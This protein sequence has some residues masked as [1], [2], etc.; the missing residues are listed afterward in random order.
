MPSPSITIRLPHS[1]AFAAQSHGWCRLAPFSLDG[2]RL[3][4][5]V[6]LPKGGARRVNI[7]WSS[8]SDVVRVAVPGRKIGEA[9]REFL[10][11]R[12]RW[13]LRADEDFGEFW[14]LCRGH[15][16]LGHCR[17]KRTGALLRSCCTA[18]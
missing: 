4:W 1:P 13:M 3:D 6:R 5:A 17:S 14:E 11:S 9:D 2:D 7:R 8:R 15:A 12:V 10:R 18:R 16:V